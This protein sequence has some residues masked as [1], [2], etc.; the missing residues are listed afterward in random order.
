VLPGVIKEYFAGRSG[1][2]TGLFMAGMM[3]SAALAAQL[4]VPLARALSSWQESLASWAV[5]SVVALGVWL[6]VT[7]HARQRFGEDEPVAREPLPWRSRTAWLLTAYLLCNGWLFYTQVSWIPATYE[8]LGHSRA[9]AGTLLTVFTVAQALSG[10]ALPA[11]ADRVN[12]LRGLI[13]PSVVTGLVGTA[14]V[15]F[16]PTAA[17]LLWMTLLGL[18]LG[19]GFALG[20]VL[21]VFYA[22]TPRASAR[23]TAMA[24]LVSYTVA[25]LGAVVFGWLRDVTGGVHVPW[26]VLAGVAL[27]ELVFVA[28]LSPR[29]PLVD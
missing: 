3:T 18:G 16:G 29:R 4:S 20:L 12:D 1:L 22:E 14:G 23:L 9:S 6:P 28:R 10:V 15:A 26:V 11:F 5:L 13:A 27:V 7:A 2:V 24:F 8:S 21:L 19:A 25:S 17:P